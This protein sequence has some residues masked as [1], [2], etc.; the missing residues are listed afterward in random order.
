MSEEKK[1]VSP[2]QSA[3]TQLY[4]AFAE[5]D[6][7]AREA[8]L[9]QVV[10][11]DVT[12]WTRDG[13]VTSAK[14]LLKAMSKSLEE[15][16]GNAPLLTSEV[17]TF[18]NVA[19]A[20]WKLKI[21][22]RNRSSQGEVYFELGEDDRLSKIVI[23]EDA[24]HYM[25]FDG[26]P[27]A[28]VEAWNSDTY[29]QKLAI[30]Q[31]LWAN[32][33]RW[34]EI[35]FDVSGASDV[36]A[37][38]KAPITLTPIDGVMDV[39]KSDQLGQQIRFQ[40]KVVKRD[41]ELIGTFTDF[42][43]V[44]NEGRVTRLAGFR[45]GASW[46]RPIEAVEPGWHWS[47]RAGYVDAHGSF[48]GGSE[49]MHLAA[50]KGK[51]YAANGYWA[52]NHWVLPEGEPRQ[53]A[54]VL[55]LDESDGQWVVDLDTG[56]QSAPEL[57]FMK[58]NLLKSVTFSRDAEGNELSSPANLLVMAAGN[59]KSHACVWV[60]DDET[61][62]WSHQVVHSGTPE[63]TKGMRNIRWVPRDIEIYTDSVTGQER[64]FLLL[65]NPGI[66]SGVYDPV[67]TNSIRWDT[68]VEFPANGMLNIRPLGMVVAN[69]EL[70]F[71]GGGTLYRRNDG[72]KPSYSKVLTLAENL[73]PEMG[74]I[75]GL[76]AIEN[77]NGDG[78]SLIFMWAPDGKSNG[79]IKR[80]DP[81]G[82]GSYVTHDEVSTGAL[83]EQSLGGRTKA[84]KTLGAYN[85][86]YPVVDPKTGELV[87]IIGFQSVI[88]NHNEGRGQ[89]GY[90]RGAKY[91][92]RTADGRYLVGEINGKYA[93]GKPTLVAPRTFVHSPFGDNQVFIAGYDTNFIPS[94]DH[95][96]VFSTDLSTL[97]SPLHE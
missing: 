18:S 70:Y 79:E 83:M 90:Y 8:I 1:K 88:F 46:A 44:D 87:H 5:N 37:T 47:Y 10:A 42:A 17:Q 64:I 52:D 72:P 82:K 33:G 2:I 21:R 51:L 40:V 58:G 96:W 16:N 59:I 54:Q 65:G 49:I 89:G 22:G 77:P 27:K 86:F 57:D 45:G 35:R 73:D 26:G 75:R 81:D 20:T 25:K 63:D 76:S 69:G 23:F 97:L 28:Y 85:E 91:A 6:E 84:E 32:D 94:T 34:V 56:A 62:K 38:M 66:I 60:K 11:D 4:D 43:E 95:A 39:I 41:G 12:F 71:S 80:L 74:G 48:A 67:A 30:L 92:I 15:N 3:V 7:E 31:E 14:E 19:R 61:D 36:A 24:P 78:E 29:D 68:D 93:E 50:H 13:V 55:R 9:S 53:S